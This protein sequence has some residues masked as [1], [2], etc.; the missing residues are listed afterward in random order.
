MVAHLMNTVT[1]E[2]IKNRIV[3]RL[4]RKNELMEKE[5]PYVE[6]LDMDIIFYWHLN[7][8]NY[9][10]IDNKIMKSLEDIDVNDLMLAAMENTPRILGVTISG[11]FSAINEYL[12]DPRLDNLI[13]DDYCPLYVM[14][15]KIKYNGAATLLYTGLLN[16]VAEKFGTDL[17]IIPCSIHELILVKKEPGMDVDLNYM[18]ELV[19]NVNQTELKEEDILSNSLYYF[20]REKGEITIL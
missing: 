19:C 10:L 16:K 5:V 2:D 6:Y 4:A 13:V 1:F 18:K 8:E 11:I 15:N 14:T 17:Y 9:G 3:Y 7:D 20:S 12:E